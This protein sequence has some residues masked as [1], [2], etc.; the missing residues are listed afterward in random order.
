M[1]KKPKG[2]DG[3]VILSSHNN[4]GGPVEIQ[5]SSNKREREIEIISMF[6]SSLER[7]DSKI[8][9]ILDFKDNDESDYDFS[10]NTNDG[11]A[12]VEL[13]EFAPSRGGSPYNNTD[14]IYNVGDMADQFKSLVDKKNSHYSRGER[15]IILLVYHTHFAFAIERPL[16]DVIRFDINR[17]NTIFKYVYFFSPL[18]SGSSFRLIYPCDFTIDVVNAIALRKKCYSFSNPTEVIEE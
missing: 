10:V 14:Q 12:F 13:T 18:G 17:Q 6:Q 9:R 1:P 11:P 16:L 7:W 15:N 4:V 8:L 5:L 3:F 2:T